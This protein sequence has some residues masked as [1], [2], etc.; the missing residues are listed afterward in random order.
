MEEKKNTE[1]LKKKFYKDF[2]KTIGNI[3]FDIEFQQS[4]LCEISS[5]GKLI[6]FPPRDIGFRNAKY[7]Q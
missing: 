2:G 3:L 6:I 7:K 1:S 5:C 4:N